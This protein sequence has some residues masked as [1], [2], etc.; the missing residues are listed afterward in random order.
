MRFI[1]NHKD[2]TREMNKIKTGFKE[3]VN[4]AAKAQEKLEAKVKNL[5]ET[6]TEKFNIQEKCIDLCSEQIHKLS[7][8]INFCFKEVQN[9][10]SEIERLRREMEQKRK[11]FD[12]GD[13]LW[14]SLQ[15]KSEANNETDCESQ[16]SQQ[17]DEAPFEIKLLEERS[18]MFYPMY[19]DQLIQEQMV[20]NERV[21]I[22]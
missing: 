3:Q 12:E 1:A 7:N 9:N 16:D 18:D 19:D 17:E 13:N 4:K 6:S 21:F 2:L 10:K 11:K 22:F 5:D 20:K 14:E 15:K 8:R